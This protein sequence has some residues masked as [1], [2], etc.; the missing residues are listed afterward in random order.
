MVIAMNIMLIAIIAC[1]CVHNCMATQNLQLVYQQRF[2]SWLPECIQKVHEFMKEKV[3]SYKEECDKSSFGREANLKKNLSGYCVQIIRKVS[4]DVY[5]E[6]ACIPGYIVT[7]NSKYYA[8]SFQRIQQSKSQEKVVLQLQ[9]MF[10][11]ELGIS[12]ITKLQE[13][14]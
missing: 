3:L 11:T 7:N 1:I 4:D 5:E 8:Y 6:I 14:A 13:Y 9:N 2:V 12:P 10:W